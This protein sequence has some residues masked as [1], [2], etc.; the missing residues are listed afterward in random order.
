MADFL[1]KN[2][3][4]VL[5]KAKREG[6]TQVQLSELVGVG[7]PTISKW[8]N[9]GLRRTDAGAAPEP[10]FRG[11]A[12]LASKLDFSLDDLAFRDMGQLEKVASQPMGLDLHRLGH[13]LTSFDKALKDQKIRGSMGK[14]AKTFA[15]AYR[16]TEGFDNLHDAKQRTAYDAMV[17]GALKGDV[18]GQRVA[19]VDRGGKAGNSNAAPVKKANRARSK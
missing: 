5:E 16:L 17:L 8:K 9:L 10:T 7:Q 19:G 3:A 2:L 1:D 6:I 18:D 15:V 4:Y 11:M 13:A 14:L 12:K